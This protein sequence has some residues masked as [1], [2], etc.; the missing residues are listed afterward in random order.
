[1]NWNL[2]LLNVLKREEFV[3]V[4]LIAA[5]FEDCAVQAA[6]DYENRLEEFRREVEGEIIAT[7]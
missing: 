3:Q 6:I 5:R 7:A 4:G 2:R 1:M